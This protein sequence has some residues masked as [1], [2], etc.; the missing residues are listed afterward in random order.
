MCTPNVLMHVHSECPNVRQTDVFLVCYSAVDELSLD[1]VKDKWIPELRVNCTRTTM[2]ITQHAAFMRITC[3]QTSM[4]HPRESRAAANANHILCRV[5]AN[6]MPRP[7]L[8][9]PPIR[10]DA[11]ECL[12]ARAHMLRAASKL[13][14]RVSFLLRANCT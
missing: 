3:E 1:N 12:R 11:H 14:P 5:H 9:K 8:T 4:L 7:P 6:P 2:R 13:M 10:R